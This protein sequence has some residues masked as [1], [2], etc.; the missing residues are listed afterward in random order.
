MRTYLV[1]IEHYD[2]VSDVTTTLYASSHRI[3]PFPPDDPDRPNQ[4]Y[5]P[6]VIDPGNFTRQM[7]S[8][9]S[10][11]TPSQ[12][13]GG[14]V[15]LANA[16]GVLDSLFRHIFNGRTL[17]ILLATDTPTYWSSYRTVML[18]TMDQ[19]AF[20]FSSSQPSQI[21]FRVRDRKTLL[22]KPIQLTKFLGNNALPDGV[23]GNADDLK[24]KPKPR[25]YGRVFNVSPPLVNTSKL[26]YQVHDGLIEEIQMVYDRGVALTQ[27][28]N[29]GSLASLLSTT[30]ASGEWD[31][32]Y[33]TEGSYFRLGSSPSG[34]ITADVK[35]D[36]YGGTYR[37]TVGDIVKTI[38]ERDGGITLFDEGAFG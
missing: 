17:R 24:G 2:P 16:D 10:L 4:V 30:P 19:A 25:C 22:N 1:E 8:G 13:N 21:V 38:A 34:G 32:Y 27:G 20:S 35:G 7:F 29:V 9:L 36:K 37:T 18:G 3:R 14:T 15:V 28:D 33:G 11:F 23:E 26:I 12:G 5:E 31:Y 6:R